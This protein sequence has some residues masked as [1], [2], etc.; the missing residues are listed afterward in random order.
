MAL[1]LELLKRIPPR[2]K[3]TAEQLH[4]QL[5]AGGINRNLRTIQRQLKAI[6]EHFDIE[7]DDRD[8]PYGYR[9]KEMAKGFSLPGLGPSESLILA[10]AEQQLKQLLPANLMKSMDGFFTQ[11]RRNLDPT[12]GA[13]RE[14][15]WLKK[16]RVVS[17]TQPLLPPKLKSN[18]F[19][20]VSDALY[21]N[22]WLW[23]DYRNAGGS[24]TKA[25]VMP[26]GLTLQ[27]PRAYL[28]CRFPNSDRERNVALHRI[29]SVKVTTLTFDRPK[30]FDL[31]RHDGDGMSQRLTATS[32]YPGLSSIA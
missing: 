26:L 8:K 22:R 18:V 31:A 32:T 7:R 16:V 27:G 20:A 4:K 17:V 11:A 13:V 6:A 29:Q 14:R 30:E 9:W 25:D 12:S 10:P 15:E 1:P 19:E 28:I 2:T 21:N 24:N 5:Q 23:I 3:V